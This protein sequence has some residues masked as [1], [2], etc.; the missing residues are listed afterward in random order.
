MDLTKHVLQQ[1]LHTGINEMICIGN[2]EYLL[3]HALENADF[4][5]ARIAAENMA[6]SLKVMERLQAQKKE[7]DG[8]VRL[9]NDLQ[10]HGV[11][12]TIV[13]RRFM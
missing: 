13:Q 2:C 5:N 1:D 12:L 10:R 6:R 3:Q 11:D 4:K 8:L 7:H 9:L